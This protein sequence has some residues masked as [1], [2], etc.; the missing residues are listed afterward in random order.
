MKKHR[1][2]LYVMIFVL[3]VLN[4]SMFV[5]L[6]SKITKIDGEIIETNSRIVM[7]SDELSEAIVNNEKE[8]KDNFAEISVV[9]D[10]ISGKLS[11]QELEQDNFEDQ[12]EQQIKV[13]KSGQGDFSEV[14]DDVVKS[15]VTVRTDRSIGTGF[16]VDDSGFVVTNQHVI[17]GANSIVVLTHD[18]RQIPA[19]IMVADSFRDVAILR[20]NANYP[21]INFADSDDL[22]VGNK[23]IAIG[24]PLGLAFTVTE[25]IVSAVDRAG[26]NGL[27][28]YVQTDVS[29]NPGNSGGPLIDTQGRLV[30]I[31]NFK[32]GDAESL[33]FALESDAL[34]SAIDELTN[35]SLNI[36]YG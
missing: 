35:S 12:V 18:R 10:G 28:E 29:L 7:V 14:I 1:N 2:I 26:P 11:V 31:N 3:L 33:G 22:R 9:L 25:G 19:Q 32:V 23:V 16:I 6:S 13:L 27:N 21:A 4:V 8:S 30:G 17:A 20:I 36:Q 5:V 15:V 34:K 24:N